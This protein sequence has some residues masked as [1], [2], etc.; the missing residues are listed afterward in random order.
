MR[1]QKLIINQ[2]AYL[3]GKMG[4]D[5]KEEG[6]GMD[7]SHDEG[8]LSLWVYLF[9]Q[10]CIL[11]PWQYFLYQ[12]NQQNQPESQLTALQVIQDMSM[13]TCEYYHWDKA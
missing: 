1:K 11:K 13:L 3:Q 4:K 8:V 2:V 7:R 10:F 9:V 6:R 5:G 12:K